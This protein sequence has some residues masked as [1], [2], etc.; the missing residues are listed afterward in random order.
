[1]IA[2]ATPPSKPNFK[3]TLLV[4]AAMPLGGLLLG[5]AFAAFREMSDQAFR[6]A[7][8]IET[9]LRAACLAAVPLLGGRQARRLRATRALA[10][11]GTDVKLIKP[12]D[13]VAW[14][15]VESPA[16]GFAEA[17]RGIRVMADLNLAQG[18]S[19]V[20]GIT[21]SVAN[22]GKSTIAAALAL[23]MA[24][25]GARVILVDCDLRNPSLSRALA[26]RPEFGLADVISETATI[27]QALWK[28]PSG[29]MDFLPALGKTHP[30]HSLDLLGRDAAKTVFEALRSSY[31]YVLVDLPPLLPVVDVV[32]TTHLLDSYLL[33]VE[34]GRTRMHSVDH[35]LGRARRLS[36]NLLGVVLNK[37]D[38][39]L[40]SRYDGDCST[41]YGATPDRR[42]S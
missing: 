7:A 23:A 41:Y 26:P 14:T 21:S 29:G 30:A 17:I 10:S 38:T 37:V 4:V 18:S 28:S 33:V 16:S 24:Q 36:A 35:A 13:P 32:A 42:V 11:E 27:D 15:A 3:K 5:F 12:G 9:R 25:A 8:Q 20:I 2:R 6:T 40:I 39:N 31:D 34:W 22:E 1:V 19:R